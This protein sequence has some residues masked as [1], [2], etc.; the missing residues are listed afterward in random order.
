MSF[1][2]LVCETC[3]ACLTCISDIDPENYDCTERKNL[4]TPHLKQSVIAVAL[5][6]AA[7]PFATA[8]TAGA[9]AAQTVYVTGSNL[10]RT[11]GRHPTDPD[12]HR[13][14]HP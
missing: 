5:A 12:H 10:K 11:E 6:L 1:R 4:N 14:G 9:E 3:F 13:Q 2:A 7:T 8:Q